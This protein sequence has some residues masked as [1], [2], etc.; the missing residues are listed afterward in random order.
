MQ[1]YDNLYGVLT[2]LSSP[3]PHIWALSPIWATPPPDC[4]SIHKPPPPPGD[5]SPWPLKRSALLGCWQMPKYYIYNKYFANKL[6]T[7][8]LYKKSFINN[9]IVNK[10]I[11]IY[12]FNEKIVIGSQR[13][14]LKQQ[15]NVDFSPTQIKSW[16]INS[17]Q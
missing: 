15:E 2:L 8:S 7:L 14:K 12:W 5:A 17:N 9:N 11:C 10:I 6:T 4:S 3:P 13:R 16:C 1:Y